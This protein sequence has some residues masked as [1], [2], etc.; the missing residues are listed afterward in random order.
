MTKCSG[1]E[2]AGCAACSRPYRTDPS[3]RCCIDFPSEHLQTGITCVQ[4][5]VPQHGHLD[6]TIA[7]GELLLGRVS[8]W[9]RLETAERI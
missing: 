3:P 2:G 6:D 9:V 7:D 8:R 1:V 5:V 4:E